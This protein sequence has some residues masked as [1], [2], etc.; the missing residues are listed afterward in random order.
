MPP[1]SRLRNH[2]LSAPIAVFVA[3]IG[4]DG[5]SA[6]YTTNTIEPSSEI[7]RSRTTDVIASD[8]TTSALA[9]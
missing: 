1:S 7:A 2:T 6:P 9:A 5:S 3:M 8:A 4:I